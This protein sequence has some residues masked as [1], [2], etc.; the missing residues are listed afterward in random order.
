MKSL[1]QNKSS[2]TGSCDA[3]FGFSTKK[4]NNKQSYDLS[5]G[6]FVALLQFFSGIKVIL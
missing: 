2:V 5:F 1:T 3:L 4:N 6:L